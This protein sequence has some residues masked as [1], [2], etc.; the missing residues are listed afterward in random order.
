[1]TYSKFSKI[2][3]FSFLLSFGIFLAGTAQQQSV[4]V[5]TDFSDD[6]YDKFVKIN[7]DLIPMQMEIEEKMIGIV[8]D[9]G[10]EVNR[11]QALMQAQQQGN[12]TDVSE[13]PEEIAK[14]NQAG[15]EVIKVQQE[16]QEKLQNHITDNEMELKKF[17]EMSIAYQQ[18]PEVKEKIDSMMAEIEEQ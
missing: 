16:S 3:I 10:L 5:N 13:D 8:E 2:S 17:Q 6:D 14:F 18:S 1:M 4:T 15:Q 7:A 12:I 11:F 9:N